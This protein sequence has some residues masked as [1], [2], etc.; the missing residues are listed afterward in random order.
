MDSRV[1]FQPRSLEDNFRH[2]CNGTIFR[3]MLKSI[4]VKFTNIM[5]LTPLAEVELTTSHTEVQAEPTEPPVKIHVVY[6]VPAFTL[7]T[8]LKEILIIP[9]SKPTL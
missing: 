1:K 2:T 3:V 5:C 7:C 8:A 9:Q 6:L 4:M